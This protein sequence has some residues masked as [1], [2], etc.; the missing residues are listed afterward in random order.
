MEEMVKNTGVGVLPARERIER[1]IANTKINPESE[2]RYDIGSKELSRIREA[3]AGD[4]V[5]TLYLAFCY[6]M[7]KGYRA[8]KA[9]V[10]R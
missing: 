10:R 8:A 5:G 7:A 9:E 1:Y 4:E 6:G 3:G 2:A